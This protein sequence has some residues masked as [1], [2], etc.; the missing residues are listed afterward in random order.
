MA[1]AAVQLLL[2]STTAFAPSGGVVLPTVQAARRIAAPQM[3]LSPESIHAS[4]VSHP[5][6]GS[7]MTIAEEVLRKSLKSEADE[8]L[9]D[10]RGSALTSLTLQSIA[11]SSDTRQC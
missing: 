4:I 9:E 7:T 6:F 3:L 5:D 10:V 1:F 2:A 11:I 8:L